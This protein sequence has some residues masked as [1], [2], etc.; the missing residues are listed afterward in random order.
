MAIENSLVQN[1]AVL[2][3]AG[4]RK[5]GTGECR[6]SGNIGAHVQQTRLIDQT[7]LGYEFFNTK[8]TNVNTVEKLKLELCR[9]AP[10][11][12]WECVEQRLESPIRIAP[13]R[14]QVSAADKR[15]KTRMIPI[16]VTVPANG[17]VSGTANF[18]C[19]I[20][21]IETPG[22]SAGRPLL[23]ETRG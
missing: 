23:V 7:A 21:M 8:E 17:D 16:E 2:I 19:Q 11:W 9:I 22:G 13:V 10:D 18:V 4:H 20:L 1:R 15:T 3:I 5:R 6:H 14:I 12:D